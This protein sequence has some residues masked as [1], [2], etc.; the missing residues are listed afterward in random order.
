MSRKFC[1][2]DRGNIYNDACP[3]SITGHQSSSITSI[4]LACLRVTAN[5]SSAHDNGE[6]N[7]AVLRDD[8]IRIVKIE[9]NF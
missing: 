6:I 5:V 2:F 7:I 4:Y 9:P 3:Y 8:V 1:N